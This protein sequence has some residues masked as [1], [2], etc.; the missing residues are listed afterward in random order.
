[1]HIPP[2]DTNTLAVRRI[3]SS[4]AG[5]ADGLQSL[6]DHCEELAPD[7]IWAKL[8]EVDVRSDLSKMETWLRDTL[9]STPPPSATRAFYFGLSEWREPDASPVICRV[10]LSGSTDFDAEDDFFE[11]AVGAAY[12]APV[13]YGD[14][15]FLNRAYALASSRSDN[16]YQLA[17]YV[18]TL[19]YAC[20]AVKDVCALVGNLMA[21]PRMPRP[22][23]VGYDAGDGVLIGVLTG[24]GWRSE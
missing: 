18:P 9:R 13:P 3:V 2:I 5:V 8:R 21:G 12:S 4:S 6:L 10:Y 7:S 19:G 22:V 1:V 17:T 24:N 14:S 11:W 15:A 23:A 20:L 16:V